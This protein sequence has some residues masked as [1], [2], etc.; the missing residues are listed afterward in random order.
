[1]IYTVY[2]TA[3]KHK[4]LKLSVK[5]SSIILA[6]EEAL[7]QAPPNFHWEVSMVWYNYP[8]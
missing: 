7:K 5:A 6:K 1:M 4:N 2:L 8:Q 3:W